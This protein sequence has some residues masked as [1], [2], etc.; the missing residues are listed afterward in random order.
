MSSLCGKLQPPTEGGT[1][2]NIVSSASH[3]L[4][5]PEAGWGRD[6]LELEDRGLAA[7]MQT[8]AAN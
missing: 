1:G 2:P 3:L 7:V 8:P 5:G 6:M 4:L